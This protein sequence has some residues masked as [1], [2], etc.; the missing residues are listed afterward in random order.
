MSEITKIYDT[1]EDKYIEITKNYLEV[2]EHSMD[3][4]LERH[5]GVFAFFGAV[6]AYAKRQLDL[7]EIG[8]EFW[9][10]KAIETRREELKSQGGKV[11]ESAL[12]NYIKSVPSVK[13][14]KEEVSLAQHKYNLAKNIVS[15]LDHQKD[16]LV[17]M[18]ANKRAEAKMVSD[19][20]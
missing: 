2:S 14:K 7:R 16:M 10:S 3:S 19:L 4:A 9:M 15:S 1:L 8:L 17:Q 18:S 5:T 12:N 6:L 13:E 20:G 11:T